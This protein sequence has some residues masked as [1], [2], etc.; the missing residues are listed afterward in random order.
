[1][2]GRG[3]VG[4]VGSTGIAGGGVTPRAGNG[5]TTGG[6]KVAA[7]DAG[8]ACGR[9]FGTTAGGDAPSV[10]VAVGPLDGAVAL[11]SVFAP[12]DDI[13]ADRAPSGTRRPSARALSVAMPLAIAVCGHGCGAESGGGVAIAG[14]DGLATASGAAG[15]AATMGVPAFEPTRAADLEATPARS[16]LD[17]TS[18]P[19]DLEPPSRFARAD[20]TRA[21]DAASAPLRPDAAAV[22]RAFERSAAAKRPDSRAASRSP[23][24]AGAE[25]RACAE[26]ACVP[27]GRP[28]SSADA[29]GVDEAVGTV[30]CRSPEAIVGC[31]CPDAASAARGDAGDV[32]LADASGAVDP[33]GEADRCGSA[34]DSAACAAASAPFATAT[35]TGAADDIRASLESA[36]GVDGPAPSARADDASRSTSA[37]WPEPDAAEKPATQ[38]RQAD[39]GCPNSGTLATASR[40]S[41]P[42]AAAQAARRGRAVAGATCRER[43]AMSLG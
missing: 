33:A 8:K 20:A 14:T 16:D 2:D 11:R 38:S 32:E 39:P 31:A 28:R 35:F 21:L 41:A 5:G 29:P 1:M 13:G 24:R 6:T 26:A 23:A 19:S 22:V 37:S 15:F 18:A 17:A 7:G 4:S 12:A 36:R 34:A 10:A 30:G 25:P 40:A 27:T 3:P 9:A 43:L 42:S